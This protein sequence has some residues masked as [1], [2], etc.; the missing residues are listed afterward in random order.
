MK[1]FFFCST[2]SANSLALQTGETYLRG[3]KDNGGRSEEAI[4]G[5]YQYGVPFASRSE[6]FVSR[7]HLIDIPPLA[8]FHPRICLTFFHIFRRAGM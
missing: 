5:V 7:H 8:E 4:M 6:L 3:G 1:T 2:Q